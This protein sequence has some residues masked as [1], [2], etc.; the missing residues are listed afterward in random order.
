M[1]R[2]IG[3]A[4]GDNKVEAILGALRGGFINILIT[5]EETALKIIERGEKNE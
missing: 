2:V 3:I 4:G 5:D 1:P